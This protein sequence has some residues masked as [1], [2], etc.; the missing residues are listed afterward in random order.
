[1]STIYD[2]VDTY[3]K[4]TFLEKE[5]NEVDNV[6]LS[7][8]SYVDLY[9]IVPEIGEGKI[10]LKEAIRIAEINKYAPK[11]ASI[12]EYSDR[13]VFVCVGED[14]EV[15]DISPMYIMK[16]T[17]KMGSFFPPDYDEK[18]LDSGVEIPLSEVEK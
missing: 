3:G 11:L 18:Y 8:I 6:I 9:G 16:D 15:W 5:F 1:M 10:T 7:L 13:F 17:G 4:Y 14:G 2:Y 12:I